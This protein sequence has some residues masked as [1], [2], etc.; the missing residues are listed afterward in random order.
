MQA[1]RRHSRMAPRS[2]EMAPARARA[3]QFGRYQCTIMLPRS[4]TSNMPRPALPRAFFISATCRN[5]WKSAPQEAMRGTRGMLRGSY[6]VSWSYEGAPP[7]RPPHLAPRRPPRR[8][9]APQPLRTT[10]ASAPP[11]V[12]WHVGLQTFTEGN[13]LNR[14]H[15]NAWGLRFKFRSISDDAHGTFLILTR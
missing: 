15:A 12:K 6:A 9:T 10:V 11:G 8:C 3:G 1:P 5:P 14:P 4:C 13:P 7:P 2:M